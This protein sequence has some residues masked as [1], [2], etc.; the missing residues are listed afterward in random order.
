MNFAS[1]IGL[2]LAIVGALAFIAAWLFD[3]AADNPYRE[4]PLGWAITGVS[5][6]GG[7]VI[8]VVVALLG[9]IWS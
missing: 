1:Q 8:G 9:F 7:V 4:S 5:G 2:T 6:V 3:P